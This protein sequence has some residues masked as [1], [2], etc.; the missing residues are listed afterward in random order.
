[1]QRCLMTTQMTFACHRRLLC[2]LQYNQMGIILSE[3]LHFDDHIL[4]VLKAFPYLSTV[5]PRHR[6]LCLGF[7]KIKFV[8][9]TSNK[10]TQSRGRTRDSQFDPFDLLIHLYSTHHTV[11]FAIA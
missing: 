11:I 9:L 2:S 3:R 1:M 10:K 7:F 8:A 4:A 6:L 5:G